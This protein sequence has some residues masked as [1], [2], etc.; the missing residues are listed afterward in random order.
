MCVCI[1]SL[2]IFFSSILPISDE[3]LK[4]NPLLL[5][6]LWTFVGIQIC[7]KFVSQSWER[8]I[9]MFFFPVLFS[10]GLLPFRSSIADVKLLLPRM[11]DAFVPL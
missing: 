6:S 2:L 3:L 1:F 7:S 5:L 10:M 9:W 8:H 4:R 11:V